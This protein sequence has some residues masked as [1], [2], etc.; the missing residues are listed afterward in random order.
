MSINGG[1]FHILVS[2]KGGVGKSTI[3][4]QVVLPFLAD[5]DKDSKISLIEVD[6]NN[7]SS[8]NLKNS[9]IVNFENYNV[10]DGSTES[11][12]KLSEIFNNKN[13]VI[14]AGGGN[15]TKILLQNM[16]NLQLSS[17][18]IFYIPVLKNKANMRNAISAYKDIKESSPESRVVFILNQVINKDNLKN[19]FSYF[20]GNKEL[21]IDGV[22]KEILKDELVEIVSLENT[23]VFDYAEDLGLT[24]YEIGKEDLNVGAV[25]AE[26]HKQGQEALDKAIARNKIYADC[27]SFLNKE[28]RPL[29]LTLAEFISPSNKSKK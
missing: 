11:Q 3:A 21:M 19:E 14:D 17:L 20:F 2:T 27:K 26:A 13:V 25:L 9:Q 7:N 16:S 8:I 6:D 1:N 4:Q 29:F 24:A 18:C 5:A 15:D 23:N 22:P 10:E 12:R 28:L